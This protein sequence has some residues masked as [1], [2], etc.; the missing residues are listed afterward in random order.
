MYI[1][2]PAAIE[3]ALSRLDGEGPTRGNMKL[4]SDPKKQLEKKG[5]RKSSVIAPTL[6][7]FR[8]SGLGKT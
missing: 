5:N 2:E 8:K 4:A 3:S 6:S 7:S 1:N